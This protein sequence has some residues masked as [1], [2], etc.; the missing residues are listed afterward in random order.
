METAIEHRFTRIEGLRDELASEVL[1]IT[2]THTHLKHTLTE[3][4]RETKQKLLQTLYEDVEWQLVQ[5]QVHQLDHRVAGMD[6]VCQR[7]QRSI[8]Q[9]EESSGA[10]FAKEADIIASAKEECRELM[11]SHE[12]VAVGAVRDMHRCLDELETSMASRIV[13]LSKDIG[14]KVGADELAWSISEARKG[15]LKNV[16]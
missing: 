2:G 11:A 5:S 15:L 7:L 4:T 8:R 16:L 10:G 13:Q 6:E 9:L 3:Q 1:K 12:Q 14:S